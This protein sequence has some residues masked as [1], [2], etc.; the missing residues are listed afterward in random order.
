VLQQEL[1]KDTQKKIMHEV[2]KSLCCE[3]NHQHLTPVRASS[4]VN[5]VDPREPWKNKSSAKEME[6]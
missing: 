3:A 2:E 1:P 5:S 6:N 4:S